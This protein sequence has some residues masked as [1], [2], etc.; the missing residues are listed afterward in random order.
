MAEPFDFDTRAVRAGTERTAFNEHSEALFLTS[1][2]VFE[3]AAQAAA[4]F[5]GAEPGY[6]YSRFS[7][8]TVS[9]FERRL[10][11]ARRRRGLPRH[12]LGHGGPD[13]DLP[14]RAEGRRPRALRGQRV[15]GHGPALLDRAVALRRRGQL[16]P[17]RR[18]RRVASGGDAA[19]A[20]DVLRDAVQPADGDRRPRRVCEDRTRDRRADASSTT[21][22]ARRWP[23]GR[24][25]SASTP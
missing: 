23:S 6:V 19:H 20:P 25:S 18:S 1:S 10:G 14:C 3:S 21:A 4:R 7:N 13:G 17:R 8:P 22:S 15:R 9:M 11:L 16:R 2:F 5:S 12:V 24:W